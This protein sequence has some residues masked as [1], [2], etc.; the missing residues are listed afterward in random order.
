MILVSV[1]VA[2]LAL[3]LGLLAFLVVRGLSKLKAMADALG[4][5]YQEDVQEG[6]QEALGNLEKA[7]DIAEHRLETL[8][9]R[10]ELNDN[11]IGNAQQ[12]LRDLTERVDLVEALSP[13]EETGKRKEE[14]DNAQEKEELEERD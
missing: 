10:M 6:I 5:F 14:K 2:C 9:H 13:S 12:M 4:A 11:V 7:I 1:V 8:S 3:A